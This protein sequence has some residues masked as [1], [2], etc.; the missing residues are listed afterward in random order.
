MIKGYGGKDTRTL[1]RRVTGVR[2]NTDAA[3][4]ALAVL[5]SFGWVREC[6]SWGGKPTRW[7]ISP[8]IHKKYKERAEQERK[9]RAENFKNLQKALELFGKEDSNEAD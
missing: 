2:G 6:G 9:K 4:K 1:T 8:V 5:E 3:R 7:E